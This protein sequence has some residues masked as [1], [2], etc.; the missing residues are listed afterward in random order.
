VRRLLDHAG[1]LG[2]GVDVPALPVADGYDGWATTYDG[3]DNGCFPMRDDVLAP[4]LDRLTPGR[5]LDA[6]GIYHALKDFA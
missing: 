4:M 5:P 1:T 3:E 6:A 2:H